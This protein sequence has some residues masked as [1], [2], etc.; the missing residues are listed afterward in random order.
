MQPREANRKAQALAEMLETLEYPSTSNLSVIW[1][2]E[3][4][5]NTFYN[6]AARPTLAAAAVRTKRIRPTSAVTV[7]SAAKTLPRLINFPLRGRRWLWGAE[8]LQRPSRCLV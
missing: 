6:S 3:S 8:L 7:L 1:I 5:R 2:G 4:H